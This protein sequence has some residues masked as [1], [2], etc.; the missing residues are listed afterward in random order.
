MYSGGVASWAA[1]RRVI[2]RHGI[3][4]VV[5]LFTDTKMEDEDL[6]R[7]LDE[8]GQ[9]LGVPVT[10]IEDGRDPW[11]VFSDVR[12]LANTRADP[13]SRILKRELAA[14]WL[15]EH[16]NRD[17]TTVYIGITWDESHRLAGVQRRYS[18]MGWDLEAPMCE[19]PYRFRP[20]LMAEMEAGGIKRPRLYTLGFAH[21]NCGGFCV[22]AGHGAFAHLLRTMPERYAYH[23]RKEQE[24]R[25]EIDK[26]V[27]IMRDRTGGE[28]T[29]MTMRALRERIEAGQCD[30][31]DMFDWG[32]CGCFMEAE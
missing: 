15:D 29:P 12:Y 31:L 25:A 23:E 4:D 26:D 32:G 22:K 5:L 24:L 9:A 30:Q 7:F 1:A 13:C 10:T 18:E 14:E 2:A 8:S 28:S 20:G 11:Q 17:T 27:A 6:Y 16:C 3:E 19:P 21:N